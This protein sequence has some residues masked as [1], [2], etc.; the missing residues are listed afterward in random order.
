MPSVEISAKKKLNLD[1]LEDAILMLLDTVN[2]R[3]DAKSKQSE[4]IIVETEVNR[5]LGIC[6]KW[7]VFTCVCGV[8]NADV[9]DAGTTFVQWGTL[10]VGDSFVAG[11]T[12]GRIRSLTDMNGAQVSG[13]GARVESARDRRCMSDQ[14]APQLKE[15]KPGTPV[16]VLGFRETP[17]PGG[18]FAFVILRIV[19]SASLALSHVCVAADIIITMEDEKSARK[20]AET[21]AFDALQAGRSKSRL[22]AKLT[23]DDKLRGEL[24]GTDGMITLLTVYVFVRSCVCGVLA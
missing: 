10:R 6:C 23:A 5:H 2:P 7:C 18:E 16:T 20:V 17:S 19:D 14:H 4:A 13:V 3:V 12:S 15:A 9:V 8:Y 21:R 1:R 24:V 11:L 22:R